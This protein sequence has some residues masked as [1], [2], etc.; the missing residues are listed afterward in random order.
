MIMARIDGTVTATV[1]HPSLHGFTMLIGM[2]VN[3]DGGECGKEPWII[4]DR[5]GAGRGDIV[6]V[7]SE[8]DAARQLSGDTRIPARMVVMGIVDPAGMKQ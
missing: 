6:V 5:L 4:L 2:Q 3:A 8:G 1:K 7:S